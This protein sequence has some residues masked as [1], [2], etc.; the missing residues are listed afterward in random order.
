M[1]PYAGCREE[2]E[3]R[4]AA[5][6]AEAATSGGAQALAAAK[7]AAAQQRQRGTQVSH[8]PVSLQRA[9]SLDSV[10]THFSGK[11]HRSQASKAKR[12]R[13]ADPGEVSSFMHPDGIAEDGSDVTSSASGPTQDASFSGR[14]AHATAS[15][16]LPPAPARSRLRP[17]KLAVP[18]GKA[19]GEAPVRKALKGRENMQ[20]GAGK[21]GNKRAGVA[22]GNGKAQ[23]QLAPGGIR[24]YVSPYSQ[25]ALRR[26][27]GSRFD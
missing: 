5:E 22:G 7:A 8:Y 14:G 15:G 12:G 10:S 25:L 17:A 9:S 6:Q 20:N 18:G 11:S 3:R 13:D 23:Q 21:A 27:S 4:A 26:V 24:Q 19:H 16:Q 2:E 1:A